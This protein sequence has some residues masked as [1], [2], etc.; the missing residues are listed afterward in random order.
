MNGT[1]LHRNFRDGNAGE[2]ENAGGEDVAE[3]SGSREQPFPNAALSGRIRTF[4]A[5]TMVGGAILAVGAIL[6]DLGWFVDLP[7]IASLG[8]ALASISGLG[9]VFLPLGL[10]VSYLGGRGI[11][12]TLGTASLVIGICLASIVDVPAI[13]DPNDLETGGALGPSGCCC[14]RSVFW[15]G[16]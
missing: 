10:R 8:N 15:R 13:L 3:H 16:S 9:L 1:G 7:A 2:L 6:I 4:G 11:L 14:S 5:L 12:A